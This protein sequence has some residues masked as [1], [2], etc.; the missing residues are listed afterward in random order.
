MNDT[1]PVTT[2][3]LRINWALVLAVLAVLLALWS[4]VDDRERVRDLKVELGRRLAESDTSTKASNLLAQNADEATRQAGARLAQIDA[5][6]ANSQQQQASLEALYK[7]LSQGRDQ[8]T[9]AEIEQVLLT[10]SQQLQLA[11]NVRAAIIALESADSRLQRSSKPQFTLLRRAIASDLARLRASPQL[12]TI[13]LSAKLDALLGA[14]GQWPLASAHA[15]AA[16]PSRAP[17]RA[18]NLGQELL[19]DIKS[20][21]QVRRI[22]VGETVLLPPDQEYF[23]RENLKLRLL[24]AR[25]ALLAQDQAGFHA[26]VSAAVAVLNQYFNTRD[27]AV[28]AA[29]NELHRLASLRIAN[30][31]PDIQASLSALDALKAH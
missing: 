20:I 11:G 1:T 6:L 18:A 25:L 13:G 21:V 31:P 28:S 4:W 15:T 30:E 19:A 23:L 24:S 3:P 7:E 10:A 5:Q 27:A 16:H 8:W 22:G 29:A 2:H 14:L 17:L 26:D 9:L 12:D